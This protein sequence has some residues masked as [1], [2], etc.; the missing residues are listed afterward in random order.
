LQVISLKDNDSLAAL[1]AVEMRTDILVLL[2]D[3]DGI[4]TSPPG[5]S[6]S[7][8]LSTFHPSDLENITFGGKSRVG[9]G[10]MESKVCKSLYALRTVLYEV[11]HWKK[12]YHHCKK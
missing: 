1:L 5:R 12:N 11:Y 10:G 8:L 9:M 7:Q 2:S 4:Y 3:V 6:D